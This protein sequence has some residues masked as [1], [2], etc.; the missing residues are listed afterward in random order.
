MSQAVKVGIFMTACLVALAVLVLR[1]EEIDLFGGKGQRIQVRFPSVVGLDD[2]APV[3]IAG[4][5]VGRVDGMRLVEREALVT[6]LL[7]QPITLTAGAGARIASTSLLGD[8]YVEL[9]P[10]PADAR[11]LPEGTV[12]EGT[13]PVTFDQAMAKIDE[14][15]GSLSGT[16]EGEGI[17]ALLQSLQETSATIRRLVE[18]NEANVS[19]TVANFERVSA[20][21][22]SELPRLTGQ[23]ERL[24]TQVDAVVAENRE[25]LRDSLANIEQVTGEMQTSVDNL[26]VVTGRLARG[27]GTLGKLMTSEEAH[28]SLVSTLDSIES[29]VGNLTETF[30]RINRIRI[31]VDAQ[32]WYLEDSQDSRTAL[33]LDVT[34]S[35][36]KFYR[37]GVVSDPSGK[38]KEKTQVITVT[39]PDGTTETTTVRTLTTEDDLALDA[40]FGFHFGEL[41]LRAGLFEST[42]GAGLD[43]DLHDRLRLSLE[44]FDFN[45]EQELE[46]RLRLFG[47]WSVHPNIYV[48]GGFDDLLES[49]RQ[50]LFLG[51]GVRWN[52]DDLKYLLG[53]VPSF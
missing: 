43:Y 20:V 15:A 51:A 33:S 7:D 19:A 29:G 45:R 46:P 30:G 41:S 10:G 2:Q 18:A 22:S 44:T 24:L 39:Q 28:D 8:K 47:R 21:L 13:T 48:L 16:R 36:Q 40:Q 25:A 17:G 34:P 4:V 31:D 52:D 32:G 23:V 26:N 50:S 42:G 38:T 49:D 14:L 35:E 1:I 6:L 37:I 12:I 5:R 27:E 53:S 9:D 11:P 3:R